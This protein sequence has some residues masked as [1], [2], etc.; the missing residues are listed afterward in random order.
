MAFNRE[1]YFM[2]KLVC[3]IIAASFLMINL[4]LREENESNYSYLLTMLVIVHSIDIAAYI[5]DLLGFILKDFKFY[6]VKC[7]LDVPSVILTVAIQIIFFRGLILKDASLEQS[8]LTSWLLIETITAYLLA[9][10]WITLNTYIYCVIHSPRFQFT[11]YL[12]LRGHDIDEEEEF[13]QKY[14]N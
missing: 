9:I 14:Y 5:L 8:G 1:V 4:I 11:Y 6:V 10:A 12:S 3:V 7:I 2:I 13:K